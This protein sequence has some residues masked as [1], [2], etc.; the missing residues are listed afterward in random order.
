MARTHRAISNSDIAEVFVTIAKLLELQDANIFRIRAYER[1][2][3][4]VASLPYSVCDRFMA[5]GE[6]ALRELPGIGEDLAAK[7]AEYCTR[8]SLRY[9]RELQ[10]E[11]P[12]GLL[13]VLEVEGMG[14]KRTRFVWKAFGVRS[15][16]D[17]K[18]L[19]RSGALAEVPGWG[20]RSVE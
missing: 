20:S 15:V 3:E 6:K 8:G 16:R 9:L 13:G 17:L 12:R 19:V 10:R 1:A 14:P 7:I 11:I 2:A 4:L 18:R 5:G